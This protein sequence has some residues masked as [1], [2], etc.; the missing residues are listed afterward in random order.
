MTETPLVDGDAP[1]PLRE[2]WDL[3]PLAQQV[4][5]GAVGEYDGVSV[6]VALVVDVDAIDR[7]VEM[8]RWAVLGITVL[9]FAATP[10]YLAMLATGWGL[11][12]CGVQ[13]QQGQTF[14]PIRFPHPLVSRLPPASV[15][16]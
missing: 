16:V 1:V 6:S 3:L 4:T 2:E 7:R 12:A 13:R 11:A 9:V 8:N 15:I 10:F 14:L 5:A